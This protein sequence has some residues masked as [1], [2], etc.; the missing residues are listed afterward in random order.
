MPET[1]ALASAPMPTRDPFEDDEP[2]SV[3]S[4]A[5]PPEPDAAPDTTPEP[6]AA[7]D[8]KAD[9]GDGRT[10]EGK[11]APKAG[12]APAPDPAAPV[13]EG[14][15]VVD[16][17]TGTPPPDAPPEPEV[18]DWTFTAYGEPVTIPGAKYKPGHGAFIPD[19]HV[20]QVRQAWARAMK[21]DRLVA[22]NERYRTE[23]AQ[24]TERELE[25]AAVVETMLPL[26]SQEW[27]E[28]AALN[29]LE[30][31][32]VAL[33]LERKKLE[34]RQATPNVRS[35]P[36]SPEPDAEEFRRT[37]TDELTTVVESAGMDPAIQTVL[38]HPTLGPEV[39]RRFHAMWPSFVVTDDQ[40]MAFLDTD[41]ATQEL[42]GLCRLAAPAV[43]RPGSAPKAAP[44]A[45]PTGTPPASPPPPPPA[46]GGALSATA[47]KAPPSAPTG[48]VGPSRHFKTAK[49]AASWLDD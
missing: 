41:A 4:D 21:Y 3:A 1:I 33:A 19:A 25:A 11:F 31:E 16:P 34:L 49:D 18:V 29:P 2:Q 45:P 30:L 40:G 7:P 9:R 43:G 5:S 42:L 14:A 47:G 46:T 36:R 35:A 20:G 37:V 24:P 38:R 27:I 8:P 39:E 10:V 48:R 32:R 17:A 15:P 22:D 6:D 23:L 13:V 26:L 44:S 28:Q 12:D